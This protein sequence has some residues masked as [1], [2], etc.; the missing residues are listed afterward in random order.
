M[1]AGMRKSEQGMLFFVFFA[2][3]LGQPMLGSAQEEPPLSE[4]GK[5]LY[6]LRCASCHGEGGKGDGPTVVALKNPPAD[7]TKI[8]KKHGGTFICPSGERCFAES[9]QIVRRECGSWP[10]WC[11]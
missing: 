8:S 9:D 11:L 1:G 3:L 10:S 6:V 7:L 5:D 4:W 2:F